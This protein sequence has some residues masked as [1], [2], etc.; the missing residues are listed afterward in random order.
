MKS[1]AT[2]ATSGQICKARN[3][4]C[5]KATGESNAFIKVTGPLP[6]QPQCFRVMMLDIQQRPGL[7]FAK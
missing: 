2:G 1:V 5:E 4:G 7:L 3:R 6:I